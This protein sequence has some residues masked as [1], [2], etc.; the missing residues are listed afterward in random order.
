MPIEQHQDDTVEQQNPESINTTG[1]YESYQRY[2]SYTRRGHDHPLTFLER[3]N[4]EQIISFVT[5]TT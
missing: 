3:W 2:I 1:G 4:P 5:P